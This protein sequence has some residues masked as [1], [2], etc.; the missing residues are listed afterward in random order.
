MYE[1]IELTLTGAK[2]R[3]FCYS[4]VES[5]RLIMTLLSMFFFEIDSI[6][7]I[8][9]DGFKMTNGPNQNVVQNKKT[10]RK[11]RMCSN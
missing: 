6:A 2:T 7:H 5:K 10:E 11:Y 8:S 9:K 1:K 3:F 4:P